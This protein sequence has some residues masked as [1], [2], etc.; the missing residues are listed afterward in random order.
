MDISSLLTG[1]NAAFIDEQYN[2]W[3][4]DPGSVDPKWAELFSE[5]D[6]ED[7]PVFSG[8]EQHPKPRS[9]FNPTAAPAG[10]A[11]AISANDL[12][13]AR[14]Q[15]RV[16]QLVN[17]YRVRGHAEADIDPLGR[18]ETERHPELT[19]EYYGL[20]EA[21]LDIPISGISI[22]GEQEVT[23]L[24]KIVSRMRR[25]YC[26]GFGVEFMNIGDPEKKKWLQERFETLP[27]RD[28][29]NNA[30]ERHALRMLS[31]AENFESLLHR[32]FPGT[33]RFSLE[34]AE[35]LIPLTAMLIEEAA[36]TGV[37]RVTLGMAHRGRLNVLVNLFN[38]PIRQIVDEFEDNAR[39]T[40]QGSGDVKYHLGYSSV[41]KTLQNREV[42][43]NL[44]FN[45]SHLEAVD[46]VVEGRARAQQDRAGD[47]S[48]RHIMPMLIHGDAAFAGQG[49]VCEVLNLSQ[50]R[51]YRTGG[52]VHIIVNNQIG[53]TTSPIDARSTPYCTDVARMLAVPIFHVNGEDV[54]AVVAVA[55]I[56]A[57]WR[58]T[59]HE[60]VIIDLYCFRKYGHNEGDEPSFT[61]PLLYDTIR[62]HPSA[63]VVYGRK[64]VGR[65]D[66][67][68]SEVE[69]IAVD[70]RR[71]LEEH[72][73]L[74]DPGENLGD[75]KS[76]ELWSHYKSGSLSDDVDTTFPRE[77]LIALLT[78]ANTIPD[79]FTPH[80]KINR[81]IKQRMDIVS[82]A[83]PVDWAVGEQAAFA[84]LV[85]QGLRIRL[86]GQDSR[87]GTFSHRHA[88][89]TDSKTGEEHTPLAFLSPNQAPF[90][91]YD[92]LLSE[93]AVLGFEFG[94]CLES[95]DA[96]VIWEAQFGDFA[97]G[98]QVLIDNFIMSTEQ[99]W[100]RLCGLVMLLPHGYEGQ[101]PEHSSARLERY[102]QLC[103]EEN[104]TV[105]NCTTPA[106]FYHLLRRQALMKIRKPLVVMS[107]KSLLRHPECISTID[108]LTDG[109]FRRV[110]PDTT[111]DMSSIDRLV[112]C[113]GKVYYELLAE[114]RQRKESRIAL[115]R[116]EQLY[117]F[118]TA[119][120]Q[121]ILDSAPE[122]VEVVWC[123][124]E[125]R[126]MGAWPMMDEWMGMSLL[127]GR[128]PRY[129][130]RSSSAS[131]ATGSPYVHA[132]EQRTLI[133][134]AMTLP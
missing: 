16:A 117:P 91:A 71:R 68:Q 39:D 77:R 82:G 73:K 50:L 125:P 26:G 64:M 115:V 57:E 3:V 29:L 90:R 112:F 43:L 67:S 17:A 60:D 9:I 38:K 70:S 40:F 79:G 86:S 96:L 88:V 106:S 47:G 110:L 118:P 62:K 81:L 123:Q 63:R 127:E 12:D 35:T 119:D 55:R 13:V 8:S 111:V 109:Q 19:L 58:Q 53:F 83:R 116:L 22:Y 4:R 31:D 23:T 105:A 59:F 41:Y 6:Q 100:G 1:D 131:P 132:T 85:D 2:R 124:E 134:E 52:T 11:P 126:N 128:L 92:S 114:R 66:L 120:I 37:K 32:R 121:P 20:T 87:R 61:Q 75:P 15:A 89:L 80:R 103:A 129:I 99:K 84:T 104:I 122:G 18:R 46:P 21:D 113:S 14:R 24:R 72:L 10:K 28:I 102:L 107:P 98:A 56:A 34:G 33:K 76:F 74:P 49:L 45:P 93:A 44:A 7:A 27:D 133:T 108:D 36:S 65:G 94:Y 25:S 5:W 69:E 51:G 101:G 48:H 78:T 130:G 42:R 30:E 97:N 54:E 95:P